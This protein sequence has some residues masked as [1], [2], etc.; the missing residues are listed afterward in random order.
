[1]S[2]REGVDAPTGAPEK[3]GNVRVAPEPAAPQPLAPDPA[4]S[5]AMAEL[6][7]EQTTARASLTRERK[8]ALDR[9]ARSMAWFLIFGAG[10]AALVAILLAVLTDRPDLVWPYFGL[11]IGV[12]IWRIWR[13]QR[14]IQAIELELEDPIDGS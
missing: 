5:S 13:D 14:R 6:A 4:E 7:R 11:G 10:P 12:Q 2:G 3:S 8:E 1:M 9:K